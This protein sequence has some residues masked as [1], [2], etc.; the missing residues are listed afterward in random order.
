MGRKVV[1]VSRTPGHTKYFQTYYLTQTV[2]LCDCPGLVFPSRVSKQLQVQSYVLCF[3]GNGTFCLLAYLESNDTVVVNKTWKR[4][5]YVFILQYE[6]PHYCS[7]SL[8][9]IPCLIDLCD[10]CSTFQCFSNCTFL[11]FIPCLDFYVCFCF[12]FFRFWQASTQCL[13]CRSHIAQLAICVKGSHSSLCWSSNIPNCWKMTV[14]KET[15]KDL[16]GQP[17]MCVRVSIFFHSVKLF[18]VLYHWSKVQ[19][20]EYRIVIHK[21]II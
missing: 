8:N 16:A 7:K 21:H 6:F 5:K 17:G 14:T 9:T 1:S 19:C 15:R 2:K 4:L 11:W 20:I 10:Y 12:T 13:N 18:A 3:T